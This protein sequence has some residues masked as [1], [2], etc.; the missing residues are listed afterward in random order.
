MENIEKIPRSAPL[1][2]LVRDK[3]LTF[4]KNGDFGSDQ[5]LPSESE[6]ASRLGVSR[7]T[8][9]AAL[10][11]LAAKGIVQRKQGSGTYVNQWLL[12]LRLEMGDQWEF[13]DLIL[14]SGYVPGLEFLDSEIRPAKDNEAESL[15]IDSGTPVLKIRKIFTADR[16][17]AIYSTN[18]VPLSIAKPPIDMEKVKGPIFPFLEEPYN[19]FPAYSVTDISPV[20]A[21]NDIATLLQVE[22]GSPLLYFIDLFINADNEPILYGYNYFTNIFPFKAIR[23]P[24]T[25]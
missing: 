14:K 18:I 2:Y 9:R 17:P 12:R 11:L 19:Q 24:H 6:L 22:P 1:E 21:S 13:E 15:K 5:Q 8:V 20:I 7:A 3:L 4:I 25:G 23:Q 16:K 10:S